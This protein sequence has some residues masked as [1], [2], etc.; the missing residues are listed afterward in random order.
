MLARLWSRPG[1]I[2]VDSAISA[3]SW[4]IQ[5]GVFSCGHARDSVR[6]T[7]R[8]SACRPSSIVRVNPRYRTA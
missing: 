8:R 4:G 7:K 6:L 3:G 1:L 2:D 5:R